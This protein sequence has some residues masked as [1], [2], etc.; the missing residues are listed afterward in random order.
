[1]RLDE[2]SQK[3]TTMNNNFV[4]SSLEQLLKRHNRNIAHHNITDP[5]TMLEYLLPKPEKLN[6]FS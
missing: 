4:P 1:M 6:S 2:A 3:N 5:S